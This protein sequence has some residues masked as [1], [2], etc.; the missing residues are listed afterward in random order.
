MQTEYLEEFVAFA[1]FMNLTKAAEELHMTQSNLGKH[2]KKLEIELG[3]KLVDYSHKRLCLTG[4]GELFLDG[5][6]QLLDNM[7]HMIAQCRLRA[8]RA[9]CQ[10][11]VQ[12]PPFVDYVAR[13]FFASI[14]RMR[15]ENPG[16]LT[17]FV[18]FNY[19]NHR[20]MLDSGKIDVLIEYRFGNRSQLLEA[21]R[22][23]NVIALP[24]GTVDF[25][26]WFDKVNA[27][28]KESISRDDIA[29]LR[30]S[31]FSDE[32][33]PIHLLLN[34]LY[35]S[36]GMSPRTSIITANS[37]DEFYHTYHPGS[38]FLLP[39]TYQD[40]FLFAARDDMVF[41]PF[42]DDFVHAEVFVIIS[43]GNPCIDLISSYFQ[44]LAE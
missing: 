42:E 26:L 1:R 37:P 31:T 17:K 28:A 23:A 8:E 11:N 36:I 10:V 4:A 30:I 9:E 6:Q 16:I 15:S 39:T 2:I 25:C 22:S 32:S 19:R 38:V 35:G 34:D 18:H 44:N 5:V 24:I 13:D 3:F 20:K 29:E 21:Y 41:I 43:R 14:N 12:D 7:D 40:N 27:P 33:S